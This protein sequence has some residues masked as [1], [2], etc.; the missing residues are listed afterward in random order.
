MFIYCGKRYLLGALTY[1][2]GKFKNNANFLISIC[3]CSIMYCFPWKIL[4][5]FAIRLEHAA[6]NV[7]SITVFEILTNNIMQIY[8]IFRFHAHTCILYY[9]KIGVYNKGDLMYRVASFARSSQN[10]MSEYKMQTHKLSCAAIRDVHKAL[11]GRGEC[12]D[13]RSLRYLFIL[14][15]IIRGA[16][17]GA[18]PG[19]L[20]RAPNLGPLSAPFNQLSCA[21]YDTITMSNHK[22]IYRHS[23]TYS[24]AL[25]LYLVHVMYVLA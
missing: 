8:A 10:T 5:S 14:N 12:A 22:T 24:K 7:Y 15:T 19:A 13:N 9:T 18:A 3:K 20:S 1:N 11:R 17:R 25:R 21:P 23:L 2:V 16:S 6:E 4:L